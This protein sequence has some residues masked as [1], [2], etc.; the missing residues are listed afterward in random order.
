MYEVY[1]FFSPGLC[2][3]ARGLANMSQSELARRA[4]VSRSTVADYERGTRYPVHNN[5]VAILRT[6]E[7]AGVLFIEPDGERG[8]GV[9]YAT[10]DVAG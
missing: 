5:L 4:H 2:R 6:L 3:A 7:Q 9:R 8:P 1:E 10:L